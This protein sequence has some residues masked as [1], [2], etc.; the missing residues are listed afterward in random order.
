MIAELL[1]SNKDLPWPVQ[2]RGLEALTNLRQGYVPTAPKTADM[3][4]STMRILADSKARADVRAEA[5]RALG[6]MQ[7]TTAVSNYNHMLVAYAAGLLAA[8]VGDQIVASYQEKGTPLN[9]T[10]A[11][12]LATLLVGPVFQ[13]FDGQT[14]VR[15]SGL[16]HS[17]AA[18]RTEIQK[19][20]DQIKPVV[21]ASLDLVRAPAGQRKARRADLVTRVAALKEFLGKNAPADRHLVPS[22]EGFFEA[23]GA[24]AD[25][26]DEP[27]AAK[28]AKARGGK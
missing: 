15:E 4:V 24:Q 3:A 20:L 23:A 17:N 1:A 7:I 13:T 2:L 18:G 27:D 25:A 9:E 10:R 5:A 11:Q 12:Y 14:G 19:I 16:L 26:P 21:Q 6:M 22:D 8:D 28:V